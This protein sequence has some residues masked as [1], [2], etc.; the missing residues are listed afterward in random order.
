MFFFIWSSAPLTPENLSVDE[1][2]LSKVLSPSRK[3][4]SQTSRS[5]VRRLGIIHNSCPL[6]FYI[7]TDVF[8]LQSCLIYHCFPE[9]PYLSTEA[10]SL[11]GS[12]FHS[13]VIAHIADTVLLL[14]SIPWLHLKVYSEN[15]NYLT[16]KWNLINNTNEQAKYNQRH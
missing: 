11:S 16:C 9:S 12:S 1:N 3:W 8:T 13:L 2:N 15:K 4:T 5:Q 6:A 14:H 10:D 7:S